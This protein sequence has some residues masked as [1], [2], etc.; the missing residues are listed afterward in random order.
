[1]FLSVRAMCCFGW[2]SVGK[3][4][5]CYQLYLPKCFI[6]QKCIMLLQCVTVLPDTGRLEARVLLSEEL[7]WVEMG[8]QGQGVSWKLKRSM[9]LRSYS[10]LLPRAAVWLLKSARWGGKQGLSSWPRADIAIL[11]TAALVNIPCTHP[12]CLQIALNGTL[13][14]E[15]VALQNYDLT[16]IYV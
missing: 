11:G 6:L 7:L 8:R 5:R 15:S 4:L 16:Q 9:C 13:F 3:V 12:K 2:G 1:M 10:L 14:R